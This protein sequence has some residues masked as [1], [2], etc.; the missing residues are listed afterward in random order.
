MQIIIKLKE[1]ETEQFTQGCIS[2]YT[3]KSLQVCL[4]K[5]LMMEKTYNN[6]LCRMENGTISAHLACLELLK[7][8]LLYI[9][10]L[11]RLL[12]F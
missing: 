5:I 7:Q 12:L 9:R 2:K 1:N 3:Y 10:T 4:H 6:V 11:T 8:S